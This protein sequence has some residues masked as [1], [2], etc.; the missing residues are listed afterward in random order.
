MPP[1]ITLEEVHGAVKTLRE[2]VKNSRVDVEKVDKINVFLDEAEE[3]ILTPLTLAK[4]EMAQREVEVKEL[5]AKLETS[6]ASAAE[7]KER[8]GTLE[9]ALARGIGSAGS[10]DFK[11]SNEYKALN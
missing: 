7:I 3:K 4:Q 9:L 8:M 11:E 1:E 6:N 10:V 2:E 5:V